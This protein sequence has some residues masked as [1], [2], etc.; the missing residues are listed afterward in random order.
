MSDPRPVGRA[1]TVA[2]W[3]YAIIAPLL[4]SPPPRGELAKEIRSLSTT[5]WR[6]PLEPDKLVQ[7]GFSTIEGWYYKARDAADPVAALMRKPRADKG[8]EPAMSN[9]LLLALKGQYLEHPGWSYTLHADNLQALALSD[10]EQYGVPVS[11]TT[12]RR[13]MKKRGWTRKRKRRRATRGQRAADERLEKLE[14]R[15]FEASHVHAIWHWDCHEGKRRVVDSVGC[16]HT[17]VAFAILDDCS[18]LCCHMQWYL[19]E[20]AENVVHGLKQAVAK[21]GLPRSAVHDNGSAMLAHETTNGL[22]D[23]NVIS[24][25]T[26]PYSPYQNGKQECFWGQ[27]EGR[28]L[29]MLESVELLTLDFLNRATQ[30]WVE[31]EYN[32][33]PHDELGTSPL[34]RALRGPSV[35]RPAPTAEHLH[36]TFTA[37]VTRTQR[38]SD[39]TISIDG[40]RFE[41]PARLRTL[42]RVC[43]RYRSWD[44]S[45]AWVI[46]PQTRALLARIRPQDKASNAD[47]R[48]RTL[49]PIDELPVPAPSADPV[50]P[51]MRKLLEDYAATGMPPAYLPKDERT[52]AD[53][54]DND[55]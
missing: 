29:A 33:S 40:V 1:L 31:M 5:V 19:T 18:R 17:P 23:N 4:I 45:M 11:E 39:G 27:V 50:P 41:I 12:V 42:R 13:R 20:N 6:H 49:E 48:R 9:E 55:A 10:P 2:T 8:S 22:R 52:L 7:P 44:R 53:A 15:S 16:W 36:R 54:E 51:L 28:L 47:G 43:V 38:R 24:R 35:A 3:R 30:A 14:V 46:D 32:R 34:E 25:P 37:E 26:L 21:R